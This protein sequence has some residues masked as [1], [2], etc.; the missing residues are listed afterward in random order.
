MY[1][2]VRAFMCVHSCLGYQQTALL[3]SVNGHLERD[4]K[5]SER[6]AGIRREV[7]REGHAAA[8]ERA[9]CQGNQ[10]RFNEVTTH[11]YNHIIFIYMIMINITIYDRYW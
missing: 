4:G 9:S 11:A 7:A 3:F 1:L 6:R 10:A 2:C 8:R 5:G